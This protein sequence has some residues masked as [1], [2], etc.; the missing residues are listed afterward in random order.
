MTPFF[1]LLR[2]SS[3]HL[4]IEFATGKITE[5]ENVTLNRICP[6]YFG[7]CSP[8]REN[9][10]ISKVKIHLCIASSYA[11]EYVSFHDKLNPSDD[12]KYSG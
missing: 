7:Y 4:V 3:W 2:F 9:P 5:N 10:F 11:I 8:L 1:A 12:S 6:S